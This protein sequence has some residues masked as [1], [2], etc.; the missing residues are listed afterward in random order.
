MLQ[1]L[2]LTKF[3]ELDLLHAREST[4]AS[5]V[6]SKRPSGEPPQATPRKKRKKAV[7]VEQ[8]LNSEPPIVDW[9]RVTE[10]L[11]PGLFY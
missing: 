6:S 3:P 2:V 7:S 11:G 1:L 9:S 10:P 8:K 4:T 5:Q